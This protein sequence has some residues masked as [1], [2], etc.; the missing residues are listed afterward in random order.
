IAFAQKLTDDSNKRL[1]ASKVAVADF[2]SKYHLLDPV[3]Q[4]A[5]ASTLTASLQA[6]L[7][8]QESTLNGLMSY[9]QPDSGQ[10][11]TL[12]GQIAATRSQLNAERARAT[13]GSA[14]DRLSL[15]NIE[16]SNLLL[17]ET[18]A[19]NTYVSAA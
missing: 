7:A 2:Q 15:L 10:L 4:S 18:L 12:R 11:Q 6:T 19:Y 1:Q 3:S 17:D 16:Y 8:T 5:A 9:M 14:D 13:A